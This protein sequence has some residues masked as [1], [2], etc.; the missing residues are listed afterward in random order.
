VQ[1]SAERHFY[2]YY[3]K[4]GLDDAGAPDARDAF[5]EFSEYMFRLEGWR[6]GDRL[7]WEFVWLC[8]HRH[9]ELAVASGTYKA[10]TIFHNC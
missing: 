8:S 6:V 7:N 4:H 9:P 2:R 5:I 3:L 10:A 1:V